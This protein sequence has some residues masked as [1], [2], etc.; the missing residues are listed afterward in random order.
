MIVA[1]A[2]PV[3]MVMQSATEDT[4]IPVIFSAVSDPV[5]AGLV[6][7]M[8]VP[9][10]N[11]TGTS[12]ASGYRNDYES[13]AGSESRSEKSRSAYMTRHRILLRMLFRMQLHFVK[14]MESNTKKKQVPLLMM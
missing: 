3:A 6:E 2:T 10:G 8:D 9:G 1:I 12:D 14:K 11:I 13:Y 7:S 5:G 4:D